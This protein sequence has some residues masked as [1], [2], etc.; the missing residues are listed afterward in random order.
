MNPYRNALSDYLDVNRQDLIR[1]MGPEQYEQVVQSVLG[2][3]Q[4]GTRDILTPG[5]GTPLAALQ[6][7]YR[8]RDETGSISGPR[9]S[10][11]DCLARHR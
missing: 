9:G 8:P 4:P 7:V 1:R 2:G 3:A 11:A 6:Q 10:A 5:A